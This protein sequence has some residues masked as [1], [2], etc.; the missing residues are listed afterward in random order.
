MRTP[1]SPSIGEDTTL[2]EGDVNSLGIVLIL[3]G[4]GDRDP[5]E[6]SLTLNLPFLTSGNP[7][8]DIDDETPNPCKGCPAGLL[9]AK[10]VMI[11]G[12]ETIF[13]VKLDTIGDDEVVLVADESSITKRDFLMGLSPAG[14]VVGVP[15]RDVS[16]ERIGMAACTGA[17]TGTGVGAGVDGAG[18]DSTEAVRVEPLAR[19][20]VTVR[21]RRISSP[22]GS[23]VGSASSPSKSHETPF[24]GISSFCAGSNGFESND[25]VNFNSSIMTYCMSKGC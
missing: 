6:V 1:S 12:V 18:V 10:S 5:A 17:G 13:S 15:V 9:D 22:S 25:V 23:C 7:M 21:G 11:L 14:M 19:P 8:S 20:K 3:I 2:R 16:T 24:S 4:A